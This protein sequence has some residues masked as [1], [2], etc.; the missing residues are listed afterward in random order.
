MRFPRNQPM[1]YSVWVN[2][3][4]HVPN[5]DAHSTAPK[6]LSF[7]V[8]PLALPEAPMWSWDVQANSGAPC[9]GDADCRPP[10][11]IVGFQGLPGDELLMTFSNVFRNA[12]NHESKVVRIAAG[13][14]GHQELYSG[15]EETVGQPFGEDPFGEDFYL[16]V[17]GA[18]TYWRYRGGDGLETARSMSDCAKPLSTTGVWFDGKAIAA[19]NCTWE[20]QV[21]AAANVVDNPTLFD[22]RPEGELE[23]RIPDVVGFITGMTVG[24]NSF[25]AQPALWLISGFGADAGTVI[26]TTVT[27]DGPLHHDKY[28]EG[29]SKDDIVGF[30]WHGGQLYGGQGMGYSSG[31]GPA[32]NAEVRIFNMA[33]KDWFQ[34][35]EWKLPTGAAS[36]THMRSLCG[37]LWIATTNPD[38]LFV[39]DE[40]SF[41][42][43]Q[44]AGPLA[45]SE[46]D[47]RGWGSQLAITR[48]PVEWTVYWGRSNGFEAIEVYRVLSF[49]GA[50]RKEETQAMH[51]SGYLQANER[52][53]QGVA[54]AVTAFIASLLCCASGFSQEKAPSGQLLWAKS[55]GGQGEDEADAVAL[56][57]A[58]GSSVVVGS[59]AGFADAATFGAGEANETTLS[60]TNGW[61]DGYVAKYT[62][63]GSLAW[64]R[65]IISAGIEL[66]RDVAIDPRDQSIVLAGGYNTQVTFGAGEP[67]EVSFPE[68]RYYDIFLAKYHADGTLAWAKRVPVRSMKRCSGRLAG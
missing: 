17:E 32:R 63:D 21:D 62:A 36:V 38:Q 2:A 24:L 55:A 37:Y 59:F 64:V 19:Y 56:S 57:S 9:D 33:V 47:P 3:V 67:S 60:P 42:L 18:D 51:L 13:G 6:S 68:P 11:K 48:D 4:H 12:G 14:A 5:P 43:R 49:P 39:L 16:A 23:E 65:P 61:G 20:R 1:Y 7:Q 50:C 29:N 41:A 30:E 53:T 8:T 25:G 52:A 35:A 10:Y 28:P 45:E 22:V 66:V 26:E 27:G 58:D 15:P 44:V 40:G 46:H 54:A 34:E 31:Q